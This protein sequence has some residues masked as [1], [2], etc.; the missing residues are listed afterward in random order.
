MK[1]DKFNPVIK[2]VVDEGR[3]KCADCVHIKRYLPSEQ[4][5]A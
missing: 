2:G 3:V 4:P 1:Q 5:Y